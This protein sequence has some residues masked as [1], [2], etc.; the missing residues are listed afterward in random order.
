MLK[1]NFLIFQTGIVVAYYS[2]FLVKLVSM[3]V[4]TDWL[5]GDTS[6]PIKFALLVMTVF[7]VAEVV[8]GFVAGK[9][10]QMIGKFWSLFVLLA[11][12]ILSITFSLIAHINQ[13]YGL[14]YLAGFLIGLWDSYSQTLLNTILSSEFTQTVEPFAVL[15]FFQSFSILLFMLIEAWL[16]GKYEND[17][18]SKT[19]FIIVLGCLGVITNV[20]PMF[21]KY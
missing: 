10:I 1:F 19:V 6:K 13:S 5:G 3:T 11:I 20:V 15:K 9:V 4:E 16:V 17:I 2:G 12:I 7:G 18:K 8:G 14:W 21:H